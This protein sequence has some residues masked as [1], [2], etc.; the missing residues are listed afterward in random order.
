MFNSQSTLPKAT[1]QDSIP[2]KGQAKPFQFRK[3]Y[4][5]QMMNH[6]LNKVT[7]RLK[8]KGR[9][10]SKKK[11]QGGIIAPFKQRQS[12]QARKAHHQI[13]A[14]RDKVLGPNRSSVLQSTALTP[15]EMNRAKK[16]LAATPEKDALFEIVPFS[17]CSNQV[18]SNRVRI[19][20]SKSQV[21]RFVHRDM[22]LYDA[23]FDP[24]RSMI[25]EMNVTKAKVLQGKTSEYYFIQS[26][27]LCSRN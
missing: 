26:C 11:D 5:T 18:I 1:V 19:L 16:D 7:D 25:I 24:L 12:Q 4:Q 9:A 17:K 13:Q 21:R 2:T 10:K 8:T 27:K 3:E 15:N 14:I 23:T 20:A 6:M 22:K